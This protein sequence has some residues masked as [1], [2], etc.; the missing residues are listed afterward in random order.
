MKF[1]L[2]LACLALFV[3]L[4]HAQRRPPVRPP[5]RPPTRGPP[6]SCRG[7][8]SANRQACTGGKNEGNSN[9]R[10]CPANAN[11]EMWWYDSRSRSCK[12]MSYKG[13]GGNNNRY[14]TRKAC[15]TKCRRRTE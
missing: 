13:C 7:A 15:E 12:K 5:T 3:A 2:I 11:R 14:C 10:Q 8:V 1:I 6:S 4:T 9:G